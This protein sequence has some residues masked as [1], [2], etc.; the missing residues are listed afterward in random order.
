MSMNTLAP[1]G[2]PDAQTPP[3]RTDSVQGTSVCAESGW[4][5]AVGRGTGLV[6]R[7]SV[8]VMAVSQASICCAS[9]PG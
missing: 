8:S 5:S 6:K 1:L 7:E 2:G 9:S 3:R 4:A